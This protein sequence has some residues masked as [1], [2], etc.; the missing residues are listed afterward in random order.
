MLHF[1]KKRKLKGG[2]NM[3]AKNML[4]EYLDLT[5]ANYRPTTQETHKR[6]TNHLI[7]CFESIKIKRFKQVELKTGYKIVEYYK[8]ETQN[9]NNSINKNLNYLK[10][11]MKHYGCY[12][13]FLKFNPLPKDTQPFLR[14]YH[15][16]LELIIQ[17]MN[18]VKTSENSIVYRAYVFLA[19]DSG[20]RK[21][22]L[23]GVKIKDIDFYK[24]LIYLDTT[25][26][27]KTRYAPFS[28]F[29]RQ[30]II[31]LI[32][33]DPEREYLMINILKHRR[34]SNNDIK[35]FYRHLKKRL[36]IDRIHTH[37]FRKTFASLLAD[38][39]MPPQYI[40]VLLDHE[41]IQTTMKYIQY[42]KMTPYNKYHIFND[43]N[44]ILEKKQI[45]M[46]TKIH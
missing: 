7:N 13:T 4:L 14:F 28:K 46:K 22:E 30:K 21:S 11:V 19:L 5:R 20:M 1:C 8:N 18:Q 32:N 43:W 3:N 36:G 12:T 37:R 17:Y 27:G 26:T 45:K 16:D 41:D 42:E 33:V 6:F 35:L 44:V 25:K 23:L 38:N 10:T 31:D 40:Q 2:Y 24:N 34:T 9:K 29:S 39:G 15:D